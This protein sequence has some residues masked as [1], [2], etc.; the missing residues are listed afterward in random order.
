[1]KVKEILWFYN[2]RIDSK[3]EDFE[4]DIEEKYKKYLKSL[5]NKTKK[6]KDKNEN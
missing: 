5:S 1:M 3:E 4:K 2:C 6:N